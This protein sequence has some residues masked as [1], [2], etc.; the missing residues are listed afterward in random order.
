MDNLQRGNLNLSYIPQARYSETTQ[1][2][3]TTTSLVLI[4]TWAVTSTPISSRIWKRDSPQKCQFRKSYPNVQVNKLEHHGAREASSSNTTTC[5][6]WP[7]H[8]HSHRSPEIVP[9]EYLIGELLGLF[10][11]LVVVQRIVNWIGHHLGLSHIVVHEL[12]IYCRSRFLH[13]PSY[14]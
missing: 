6:Q 7:H 3:V 10:L 8:N 11:S 4:T 14:G 2:K 13:M 5:H 1:R 12:S 9:K